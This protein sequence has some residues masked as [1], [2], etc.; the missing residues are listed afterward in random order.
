M[1]NVRAVLLTTLALLAFAG[2]SLL[3][4]MALAHTGMDAAS[5]TTVRLISGALVLW[6]LVVLRQG[7]SQVQGSWLSALALFV[8]AAGFSFAYL[9]LN[10]GIGAL[11]LFGAVQ[12]GMIGY[13]LWR[14]ERFSARQWLGLL[15]ACAGLTGLLL[16]GLSAPPLMGSMLMLTA[17]FAWA[18][19][20]LRGKGAANPLQVTAGNFIRTLP[21]TLL[22]SVVLFGQ[23]SFDNNGMLYAV[24]S[25]ALTS[26]VGYAIWYSVLPQL[27]ATTAATVQLTV[28]VLA[29]IAGILI[30][31]EP[32]TQRLILASVAILGGIALVVLTPVRRIK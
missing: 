2:N 23:L 24:L 4:R 25:G 30:L 3:C 5:F 11:I 21:M 7:A 9:Q 26:G 6:L 28:P 1:L 15:M 10:T 8:Y 29:A 16:P 18:V 27:K 31:S 12:S 14:G 20:S 13:G 22:L 19:Y 17:G 32:L